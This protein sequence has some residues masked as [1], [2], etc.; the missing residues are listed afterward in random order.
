M[1]KEQY[2]ADAYVT[3]R[4]SAE[5]AIAKIRQGQRVFVGSACGEPQHLVRCLA[6]NS[7]KFSGLEIVRMMSAESAPLTEIAN[8]THDASLN[9]RNIYLGSATEG[10]LLKNRRFITPMNMSD[11][12][13]LFKSRKMPIDVALIQVSP[14]DDFGWMS[15]G[16]SVDVTMAAAN[17]ARLGHCPGESEDAQSDGSFLY[18]CERGRF[19]GGA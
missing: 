5:K 9:V 19:F 4:C 17:S 13:M 2:W 10:F 6:D 16:V 14:P 1:T 7:V 18:P 15:F 8:K 11:V 3:K 12:P